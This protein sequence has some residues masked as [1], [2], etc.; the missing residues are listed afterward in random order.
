MNETLH[1]MWDT[2]PVRLPR[3]QAS[4]AKFLGVCEG[5]GVRYQI[6]PTLVR[7]FFVLFAFFRR[8]LSVISHRLVD[9]AKIFS[10]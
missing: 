2:R 1:Q 8:R 6:D 7:I 4:E 3:E 9:N 5:I 10:G